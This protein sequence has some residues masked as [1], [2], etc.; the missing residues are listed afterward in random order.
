VRTG[1]AQSDTGTESRD[2]KLIR[3]DDSHAQLTHHQLVALVLV[4]GP[5]AR[6]PTA[7]TR[8]VRYAS[9]DTHDSRRREQRG[10]ALLHEGPRVRCQHEAHGLGPSW[11][12]YGHGPAAPAP[13]AGGSR[14][15]L[16]AR[17]S[18]GGRRRW[19]RAQVGCGWSWVR[20]RVRWVRV[21]VRMRG[22]PSPRSRPSPP[23]RPSPQA[24][25]APKPA[26]CCAPPSGVVS[27]R[28]APHANI[29]PSESPT[30]RARPSAPHANITP[31][32]PDWY[33]YSCSWSLASPRHQR[34]ARPGVTPQ[35]SRRPPVLD[36]APSTASDIPTPT[37]TH[38]RS[39]DPLSRTT[40]SEPRSPRVPT[41]DRA[42][43]HPRAHKARPPPPPA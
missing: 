35:A 22:R 29:T 23:S 26:T 41:L 25:R 37:R 33:G 36:R 16:A 27:R 2:L 39:R 9:F 5:P 38:A 14:H 15:E 40:A 6:D 19:G 43:R 13:R 10:D 8:V 1:G 34:S 3:T 12:Q 20:V 11:H 21:R 42:Q 30:P 7:W 31:R 17:G 24:G 32:K 4:A 28:N 18:A